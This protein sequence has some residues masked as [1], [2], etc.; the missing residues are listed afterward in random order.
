STVQGAVN[1][2]NCRYKS[3]L[4]IAS[5]PARPYATAYYRPTEVS[6]EPLYLNGGSAPARANDALPH[7]HS[8]VIVSFM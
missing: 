1:P 3:T 4:S 8:T 5:S 6:E 2:S 7:V